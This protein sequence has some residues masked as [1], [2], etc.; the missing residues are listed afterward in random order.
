MTKMIFLLVVEVFFLPLGF[1]DLTT[2]ES[3]RLGNLEYPEMVWVEGGSFMMGDEWGVGNS[4]EYPLHKVSLKTFSISKTEVTVLQYRTYCNATGRKMPE[5][6]EWGWYDNDPMVN[7]TW[8]D[9]VAYCGWLAAKTGKRYRLPTEAEWEYAA[10]G[11]NQSREHQYSGGRS[12]FSNGW[13]STNSNGH[14]H[15]VAQKRHNELGLYDMSG[16]VWEWCSDCYDAKYYSNCPV[17]NPKGLSPGTYHVMR[18]GGWYSTRDYCRVARRQCNAPGS[19]CGDVGF[20]IA[21][22]R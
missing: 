1:R 20:R 21:L 17:S 19:R 5:A 7:L 3:L 2:I 18:G 12:L 4:D 15:P 16:N 14:A 22:S 11:G 10:R 8:Y 9:A 6:P 13:F